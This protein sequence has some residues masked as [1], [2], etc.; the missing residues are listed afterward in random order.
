VIDL[1]RASCATLERLQLPAPLA[2]VAPLT[3]Q[4]L[5]V[6]G[7]L[8]EVER[9]ATWGR[10]VATPDDIDAQ[11]RWR[12]AMS[13]LR[14]IQGRH[15]EAVGL[16]EESVAIMASTELVDSRATGQMVL[17]TALRRAGDDARA[18]EVASAAHALMVAKGN[19][20]A[21]RAITAFLDAGRAES[22]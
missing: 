7:Q 14:S 19:E 4:T 5:L 9:F 1:L 21:I 20:T 6:L 3:A 13:G 11:A 22:P 2:T 16:A 8:D 18:V 15:D 17:A 12:N 10:D